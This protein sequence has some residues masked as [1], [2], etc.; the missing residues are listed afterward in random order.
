MCFDET[1]SI[2]IY[3]TFIGVKFIYI[4]TGELVKLLGKMES[5]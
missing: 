4:K 5:S 1:D 2:L 3:P